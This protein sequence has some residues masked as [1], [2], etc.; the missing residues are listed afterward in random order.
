MISVRVMVP[1]LLSVGSLCLHGE[2]VRNGN[3]VALGY[4]RADA[5]GRRALKTQFEG[6][7]LTFRFLRVVRI[8][9][10]SPDAP[11]GALPILETVEPSSELTVWVHPQGAISR[12]VIAS[13]TT[14]EAVAV[15]GRLEK[16]DPPEQ[17][18][19]L[20]V[21]PAVVRHKDRPV[22]KG[23]KELLSEI[24]PRAVR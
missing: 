13:L 20:L 11:R 9:P 17:P 8:I 7:L 1:I 21:K 19:S 10:P 2:T 4:A 12:D 6:K 14:N 24:D 16:L 23:E 15:S 22:P 5:E 3:E 18:L